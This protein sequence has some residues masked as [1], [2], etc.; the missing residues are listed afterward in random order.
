VTHVAGGGA[1]PAA[2]TVNVSAAGLVSL[3]LTAPI[4]NNSAALRQASKQGT[5]TFTYT[6]NYIGNYATTTS[7]P[8]TAT[9]TVN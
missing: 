3:T 7:G 6:E 2:A 5:Y 9:I 1:N 8:V 4:T